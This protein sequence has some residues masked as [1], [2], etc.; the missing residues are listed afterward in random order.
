MPAVYLGTQMDDGSLKWRPK[1]STGIIDEGPEDKRLVLELSGNP[2]D[3]LALP[4]VTKIPSGY[5]VDLD[6]LAD[7]VSI[8]E[9]K[10][11]RGQ[12][13]RKAQLRLGGNNLSLEI[14]L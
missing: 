13:L 14:Q 2:L 9:K 1:F 4:W 10:W 6:M 5:A 11:L 12:G 8:F 7:S 3:L